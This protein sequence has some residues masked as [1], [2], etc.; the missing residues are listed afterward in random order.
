MSNRTSEDNKIM[1]KKNVI[2]LLSI[3]IVIGIGILILAFK[4]ATYKSEGEVLRIV[5]RDYDE[6]GMLC[7]T[8]IEM[9]DKYGTL[10]GSKSEDDI[11][12]SDNQVEY[13]RKG[14]I[15]KNDMKGCD[16]LYYRTKVKYKYNKDG[17]LKKK[18]EYEYGELWPDDS[19]ES[20]GKIV[21]GDWGGER[22]AEINFTC[23]GIWY[24]YD[25]GDSPEG[26]SDIY[27]CYNVVGDKIIVR[28]MMST[29]IGYVIHIVKINKDEMVLEIDGREYVFTN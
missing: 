21:N 24:W 22:G 7:G 27:E 16:V 19:G 5:C 17:K 15:V 8:Y 10:V 28:S 6:T 23:F 13:N 14:Q 3:F 26:D 2:M 4:N 20:Y 11:Y 12:W 9:Y 25:G 18:I 1:K 29:D